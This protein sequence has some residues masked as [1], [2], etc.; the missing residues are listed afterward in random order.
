MEESDLINQLRDIV[1]NE[2][3]A[4][5]VD[6]DHAALRDK[7]PLATCALF[8]FDSVLL[9]GNRTLFVRPTASIKP[10]ILL[11]QSELISSALQAPVAC[12]LDTITPYL[13]KRLIAA[14]APFLTQAGEFYLPGLLRTIPSP[15]TKPRPLDTELT[16]MGKTA[17]LH[18]LYYGGTPSTIKDVCARTGLSRG[19]AQRACEELL[20]HGLL[21]RRTGG[22][23]NRTA[24]YTVADP[25]AYFEKGWR[26]FGRT[27]KKTLSLPRDAV[28]EDAFRSGLSALAARTLLMAPQT[29]VFAIGP[30]Q[31]AN[32]TPLAVEEGDPAVIIQVLAFDPAPF[33]QDEAVD[34]FT[35]LKTID[36]R[37]ERID[38]AVDEIK[39]AEGW[40]I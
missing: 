25:A 21:Q 35:M 28:P 18:F 14:R 37:D 8:S 4:P 5:D 29:S 2:A 23:T 33:A 1:G 16:A 17:F 30:K 26:L 12:H 32:L 3:I 31:A 27:V 24:Y 36:R 13:R 10:E 20:R 22:P 39:E 19:G 40:P 7:L 34:P 15:A 11:S 38:M 6:F 9:F